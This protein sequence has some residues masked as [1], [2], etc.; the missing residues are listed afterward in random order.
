[1]GLL[2]LTAYKPVSG[3]TGDAGQVANGFTAIETVVN[4]LVN[5]NIDAAAAIDVSKL[6]PGTNG[7]ALVTSGGV[8]V[9]GAANAVPAGVVLPYTASAA[10]TGYLLCDGTA[11]SRT[12]YSTLFAVI[13]TGYG[14]GDGAT[15]FN[16]PDLRG[17]VPVGI[18]TNA[19]VSALA[20]S[21]GVAVANRRPQHRHTAHLHTATRTTGTGVSGPGGGI[22]GDTTGNTSSVDGG[23]GTA[24]DSL[25]A[26]AFLVVQ[27]IIKT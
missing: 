8:A 20:T 17:R 24:T 27:Y 7:Q 5:A 25:D 3:T 13:S 6:A 22:G 14:T 23:S 15:T 21:D 26:P 18:G 12:T 10:P 19:A 9:W 2:N 4:A 1:M 11:V 16:L